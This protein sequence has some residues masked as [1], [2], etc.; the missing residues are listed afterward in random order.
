M[1]NLATNIEESIFSIDNIIANILPYYNLQDAQVSMVKFKDTDKQRAVYKIDLNN[2]SFC[3]KK[4]YFPEDELLYVY[5]ALEWLHRNGINVPN[6]LPTVNKGRYVEYDNM[7]FILTPW[8]DGI[9]CDFDNL[10][11]LIISSIRLA[12]IHKTSI[13][14]TPIVGSAVRES[15]DDIYISTLKHFEQLLETS[16]LAFQYKDKFSREFV[17]KFD[18][19]LELGKI[20][21]EVSSTIDINDLSTSLC[22]GDYVNKN[23]IFTENEDIWLIDFDKCKNDYCAHDL[24]YFLRRLLKRDNTKWDIELAISIIKAYNSHKTLTPSDLKYVVSYICFPQKYWKISRDYYK[25]IRKCNKNSF[26]T[27]LNKANSKIDYQLEF[28][29]TIVKRMEEASW[30]AKRLV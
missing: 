9:K 17:D 26:L 2:E 13:N 18:K 24:S 23:I 7:L 30:C 29:N 25:N 5:S 6:L 20:A 8:I 21:L 16:N 27:L 10:N 28:S 22:H 11:H 1:S 3:L 19:N 12:E 15:F 14:F 4:V